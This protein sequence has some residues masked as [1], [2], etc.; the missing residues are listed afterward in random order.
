V[1]EEFSRDTFAADYLKVFATLVP[2]EHDRSTV[3]VGA[4][5]EV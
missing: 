2:D 5:V 4:E 3:S 1:L